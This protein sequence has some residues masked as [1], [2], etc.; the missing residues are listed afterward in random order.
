MSSIDLFKCHTHS[1]LGLRRTIG[2][3][4]LLLPFVMLIG[5]FLLNLNF[6]PETV[7]AYYHTGM[8]N[9]FVGALC[10]V[11]VFLFNYSGYDKVDNILG[12]IG[13][14]FALGVAFLPTAIGFIAMEECNKACLLQVEIVGAVH[15]FCAAG[16]FIILSVFSFFRFIKSKEGETATNQKLFRNKIYRVCGIIKWL[17]LF[18]IVVYLVL[19]KTY[20]LS[21]NFE[22]WMEAAALSAFGV[23]WLI[24]GEVLFR[25]AKLNS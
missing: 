18:A 15:I 7:S 22:F 11:A 2:L 8:R 6:F 4:G 14:V 19:K 20:K 16:L 13:G 24:K 9:I 21:S 12:N 10:I 25:D 17:C 23:S 1:Y 3:I 5:G